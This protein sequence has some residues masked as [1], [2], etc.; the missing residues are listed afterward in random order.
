MLSDPFPLTG[1]P[2][3]RSPLLSETCPAPEEPRRN[4]VLIGYAEEDIK[5]GDKLELDPQ[6]GRTRRYR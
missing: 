3:A 6:T 5:A 2:S 1:G 4:W